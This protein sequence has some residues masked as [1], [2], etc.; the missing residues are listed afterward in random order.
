[1]EKFLRNKLE[2][3]FWVVSL[4]LALII[5]ITIFYSFGFLIGKAKTAFGG[6]LIKNEEI[7]KFNLD[8]AQS[9]R[10]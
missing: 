1:M 9:L 2:L 8:Q 7:V 5:F 6:S 3:V 10:K 4:S